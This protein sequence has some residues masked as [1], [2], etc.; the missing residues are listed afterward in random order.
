M[1][2]YINKDCYFLLL[3]YRPK[4]CHAMKKHDIGLSMIMACLSLKN[5]GTAL[6][7]QQC[8]LLENNIL[9]LKSLTLHIQ[10]CK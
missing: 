6:N 4:S 5:Y 8:P 7:I 9:K 2:I 1:I 10:L 3:F